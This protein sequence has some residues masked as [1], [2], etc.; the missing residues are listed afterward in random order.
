MN[1]FRAA[2]PKRCPQRVERRADVG[3]AIGLTLPVLGVRLQAREVV[4]PL[5]VQ[6]RCQDPFVEA[7][8][9]P[10]RADP[11]STRCRAACKSCW[12]P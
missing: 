7:V 8:P 2:A 3:L 6:I 12:R 11:R 1:R 4:R 10:Q 5:E 9:T